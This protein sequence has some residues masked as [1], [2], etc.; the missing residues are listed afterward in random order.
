[1]GERESV[2]REEMGLHIPYYPLPEEIQQMERSETV[3]QYC[4]VSYLILHE[5]QLLQDRLAQ[6]ERELQNQR[7][8]TERERAKREL[9]EL[10][11][12]EWE[13]ALREEIQRGATEKEKVLREEHEKRFEERRFLNE[14]IEKRSEERWTV[15]KEKLQQSSTHLEEQRE[16]L[17]QLEERLKSVGLERDMTEGLLCKER[18][19][20]QQ[21]RSGGGDSF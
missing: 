1:M 13:R 17:H 18:E 16:D 19:L 5:F 2:E 15:L 20:C 7:G 4:G 3:C 21:L 14:E 8:A 6:V 10:G 9:L 12:E 11:R